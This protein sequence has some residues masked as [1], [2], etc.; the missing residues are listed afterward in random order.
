MGSEDVNWEHYWYDGR[1]IQE[2]W[3]LS[4]SAIAYIW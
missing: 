2:V 3:N 4:Y 1:E